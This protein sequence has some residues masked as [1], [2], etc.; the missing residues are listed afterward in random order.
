MRQQ[1][2]TQMPKGSDLFRMVVG[3][4]GIGTSGPL[5]ALSSMPIPALIFWRNLGG[6]IATLPLALRKKEWAKEHRSGL[7]WS[8]VAGIALGLHFF[9]FFIAM[10]Y[11]SVAAGVALTALQPIF[12]ALFLKLLGSHIPT[13]AWVGM[14]VSL[15]GVLLITGVD[16][17]ISIQAFLG[18]VAAIIGAALA[19]IYVMFGAKARETVSTAS[20]TTVAYL[21]S[22][23]VAL[24]VVLILGNEMFNFQ[25]SEWLIVF[26]LI[27]GAQLLGHSMFNSVLKRV[28]PAVVSLIVFFEVPVG[29]ILAFWWLGQAPPLG[30][31]PGIVLIL[32]GCAIVVLRTEISEELK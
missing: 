1:N 17:S 32:L 13:K 31:I 3:V 18:D 28:S 6:A 21:A 8:F 9:G 29:A 27:V 19:A 11:T 30:V 7:G 24:P 15:L 2:H 22:A 23:L 5:I 25:I 4:F 20:Y 26:G 16:F 14:T 10:R 12:A